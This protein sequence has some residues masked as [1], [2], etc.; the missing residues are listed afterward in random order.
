[1]VFAAV[2]GNSGVNADIQLNPVTI[3]ELTAQTVSISL[4][5]VAAVDEIRHRDGIDPCLVG[6]TIVRECDGPD[7]EPS[8]PQWFLV[9]IRGADI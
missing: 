4:E 6:A 8:L 5:E 7:T 9:G 1:V 3:E 2:D